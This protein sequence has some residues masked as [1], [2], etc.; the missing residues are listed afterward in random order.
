M[1]LW[2]QRPDENEKQY[3]A[4]VDYR[5][6]GVSRSLNNLLGKYRQ[7]TANKPPTKRHRTLADWSTRYDWQVR[8]EAWD[9]A[10]TK[11]IEEANAER[12]RIV[13]ENAWHDYEFIRKVI[14]KK[15][16][17]YSDTNYVADPNDIRNM[18]GLMKQADDYVRRA[19]GLPDKISESKSEV[20]HS[21]TV[22]LTWAD[23]VR[24]ARGDGH[25]HSE[26]D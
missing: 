2:Q 23:V 1:D 16:K 4:F 10:Q 11:S 19:V 13:Q 5:D 14:D 20:A 26:S 24:E 8:V 25:D 6:M 3:R 21:G 12:R 7:Q 15:V 18:I 22:G 9:H 17:L